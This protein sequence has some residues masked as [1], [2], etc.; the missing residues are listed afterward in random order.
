MSNAPVPIPL[1]D[2]VA[3]YHSIRAEVDEAIAD[4]LTGGKFIGG[5]EIKSFSEQFARL[6]E[7]PYCVPCANGTDALEI[8]LTSL[9]VG[10][11][12]EVIIPAFSFAATLEAVCNVG[13]TPILCDIDP[14]RYT[15][16]PKLAINLVTDRTKI[17]M[18]VHLYGQVADMDP[19]ISFA[20][21]NNMFVI[22]DAAQAHGAMYKNSKAGS[23][24]D[25]NTFSF[26]PS[27]N[28]GAYG[29]AGAMTTKSEWLYNKAFR[30]ANHGRTS[31]YEHEIVGR[32]SRLDTLQAAILSVKLRHLDV[33][34]AKRQELA[35]RYNECL[36]G[37]GE[38]ILP[39]FYA[40]SLSVFHVYVIRVAKGSR[41]AF[42]N[43]LKEKGI[44]TG[45]HYPVA[46]SKL[47]VTTEQLKIVINCPESEKASEEV[48]SLP[49]YPEMTDEQ[50]DYVCDCIRKFFTP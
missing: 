33:W 11:G 38:I 25:I 44:E 5:A 40:D 19:L 1:V 15:I 22:E 4:I 49:L 6:C 17:F 9:G 18:P 2:L 20:S 13:A 7:V 21:D 30:I 47:R 42:M 45:S 48:V 34:T 16:D 10:V 3:Q 29:D 39:R 32:N 28:L 27:K 43:Y 23:M 8:A 46:L 41:E 24:G 37:V 12:D 50:Q 36:A 31:K 14:D 35:I 26:Y